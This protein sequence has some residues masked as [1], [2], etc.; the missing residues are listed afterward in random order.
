MEGSSFLSG[1]DAEVEARYALTCLED[2]AAIHDVTVEQIILRGNPV[3]IFQDRSLENDLVVLPV[4]GKSRRLGPRL[5]VA[6]MLARM[7]QGSILLVPAQ[8]PD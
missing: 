6:G 4:H 2:D 3:R 5:V 8:D 1:P 7:N